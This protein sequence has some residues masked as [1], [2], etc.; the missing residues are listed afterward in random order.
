MPSSVPRAA[1]L[2]AAATASALAASVVALV[3]IVLD[4]GAGVTHVVALAAGAFAVAAVAASGIHGHQMMGKM[5]RQ[6]ASLASYLAGSVDEQLRAVRGSTRALTEQ[7]AAVA[8]TAATT[9][10]VAATANSIAANS[11]AVAAAAEQ[12]A[13]TMHDM[14]QS[15][16]AIAERTL[17]LGARSQKIGE[18]L[19]LIEEIS[20]QTNLLA[21]NA[22]IEAARAGEAGK[23]F[24]VVAAEVRKLAERSIESTD[25]I[26]EIVAGVQDETNATIMATQQ[27]AR[28]A[29]E[30]ANLMTSTLGMLEDAIRA[31]QQQ[32][33][34]TE[35]LASAVVQI[36]ASA[37]SVS[38]TKNT[39][40]IPAMKKVE[41]LTESLEEA[42]VGWGVELDESQRVAA[43]RARRRGDGDTK[44]F[45][46]DVAP[47]P[48]L[49]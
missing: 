26:R 15:V 11:R 49:G 7:A 2:L 5:L 28:Q 30:V 4:G 3:A 40:H 13:E 45:E 33:A 16:E 8:E 36:R 37:E 6:L 25:S 46:V 29:E 31:T 44:E 9:E 20:E 12:T 19:E 22:A 18:I 1:R 41:A 21:L 27:G 38:S 43:R 10:E 39:G 32:Q 23:G 35:Q 34:A 14:R 42:V 17:G 47:A 24:A 48:V